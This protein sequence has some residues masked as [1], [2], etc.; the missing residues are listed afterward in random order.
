RFEPNPRVRRPRPDSRAHLPPLE[1]PPP[2]QEL[3]DP[4]FLPEDLV[5]GMAYTQPAI[6]SFPP[7]PS[8]LHAKFESSSP[9]SLQARKRERH[10]DHAPRIAGAQHFQHLRH[11]G[12]GPV[13]LIDQ[14]F[15]FLAIF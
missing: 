4:E 15:Q 11:V 1:K 3:Q 10:F 6:S 5:V 12:T 13:E 8:K 14:Q 2:P 9:A 7:P